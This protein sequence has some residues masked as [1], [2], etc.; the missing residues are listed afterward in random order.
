MPLVINA[1][2][3]RPTD[4]HAFM[5]AC[6]Q[7]M[8]MLMYIPE[9]SIIILCFDLEGLSGESSMNKRLYFNYKYVNVYNYTSL[10]FKAQLICNSFKN[11]HVHLKYTYIFV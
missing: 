6:T 1:A 2:G 11:T 4:T 8:N 7:H 10:K 3:D 9:E 5:H